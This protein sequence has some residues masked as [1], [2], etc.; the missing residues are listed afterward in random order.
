MN[1]IFSDALAVDNHCQHGTEN[2]IPSNRSVSV[3]L[4]GTK[5]LISG[6][7]PIEHIL[8]PYQDL[9]MPQMMPKRLYSIIHQ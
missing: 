7:N 8:K 2:K 6:H 3:G 1:R 5:Q 4:Q 9:F